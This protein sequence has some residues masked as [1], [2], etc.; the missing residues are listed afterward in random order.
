MRL[1]AHGYERIRMGILRPLMSDW[2]RLPSERTS[3]RDPQAT[4]PHA[5]CRQRLN[6][7]RAAVMRGLQPSL[8][9]AAAAAHAQL[10]RWHGA[11][12]IAV[13]LLIFTCHAA[14]GRADD[15]V[16]RLFV[17][18]SMAFWLRA[19]RSAAFRRRVIPCRNTAW[20]RHG[21]RKYRPRLPPTPKS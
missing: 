11:A 10:L 7:K 17:A 3:V 15:A 14:V 5:L 12:A 6:L 4:R 16:G 20:W 1:S 2:S 8:E 19:R 18:R 21:C 13:G 9:T